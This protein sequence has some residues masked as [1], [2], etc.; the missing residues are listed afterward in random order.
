[1]LKLKIIVVDR[2]RLPFL[3]QGESYYMDRLQRYAHTEWIE[4][5]PV[6]IK[7]GK[8][9]AEITATEGN[10]LL[11]N[12]LPRD[13]IVA[14]DR[15]GVSFDSKELATWIETLSLSYDRIAFLIGGPLGL[16]KSVLDSAHRILSLSRLTL[17]HEMS[18]LFLLE[19]LYRALT[20]NRGEKYH[21]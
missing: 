18:R 13:Y 8:P 19:Q 2:T 11:K 1:M 4:V 12:L 3:V 5:R 9:V 14:L 10:S 7:K 6:K 16:S 21:K 20:I 15:T 17:T